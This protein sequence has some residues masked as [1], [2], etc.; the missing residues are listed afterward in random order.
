MQGGM[1]G[2]RRAP[3]VGHEAPR[4]I[5]ARRQTLRRLKPYPVARQTGVGVDLVPA[6]LRQRDGRDEVRLR[7]ATRRRGGREVLGAGEEAGHHRDGEALRR[8][9]A[10]GKVGH[11]GHVDAGPA[12]ALAGLRRAIDERW[13][14]EL[15]D[16]ARG[17]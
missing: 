11:V 12:W 2:G 17:R 6:R 3:R 10:H 9:V 14:R 4:R 16:G 13:R 1:W 8:R 5:L 7:D 15:V